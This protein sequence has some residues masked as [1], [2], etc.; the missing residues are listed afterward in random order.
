MRPAFLEVEPLV[1]VRVA[2]DPQ[3]QPRV[4]PWL[5][6]PVWCNPDPYQGL[7]SLTTSQG[8]IPVIT[9]ANPVMRRPNVII[10]YKAERLYNFL[11]KDEISIRYLSVFQDVQ[12]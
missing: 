10:I 3:F 7:Y 5:I 8:L 11:N 1:W 12:I 4:D 2:P 9:H 6:P